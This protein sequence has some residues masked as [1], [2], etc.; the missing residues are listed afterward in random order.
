[1]ACAGGS[2]ESLCLICLLGLLQCCTAS[3]VYVHS[4]GEQFDV[5]ARCAAHDA[6]YFNGGTAAQQNCLENEAVISNWPQNVNMALEHAADAHMCGLHKHVCFSIPE[7]QDKP[8]CNEV[9]TNCKAALRHL[10]AMMFNQSPEMTEPQVCNNFARK[11]VRGI[12]HDFMSN[13]VDGSILSE[14]D[15]SMNFGLCRWAQYINVLSDETSCDPGSIIAMA[16]ELGYEACGVSLWELDVA[17]KPGVTINR[18]YPCG[19]NI[20]GSPMFDSS[21][22]QRKHSFSDVQLA[23]NSTAMEESWY[24]ANGHTHGI[25]DGEVEYSAEAGAAA[26]AIGRVTCPPEGVGEEGLPLT[27][28]TGFFHT[29]RGNLEAPTNPDPLAFPPQRTQGQRFFNEAMHKLGGT[30]CAVG[31]DGYEHPTAG[32]VRIATPQW[33][34]ETE[35]ETDFN[36]EGG[37]C[38]MPTQFLG[39]VRVGGLHRTPRWVSITQ[40]SAKQR[41]PWSEFQSAACRDEIKLYLPWELLSIADV[42]LPTSPALELFRSIAFDGVDSVASA[43]DSCEVGCQIPIMENKLCGGTVG[44]REYDFNKQYCDQGILDPSGHICCDPSC[45]TC[46]QDGQ[47]AAR[48][49]GGSSDGDSGGDGSGDSSV[50]AATPESSSD[51]IFSSAP[52]VAG[53]CVVIYQQGQ[54]EQCEPVPVWDLSDWVHPGGAFVQGSALCGTVRYNWLAKGS[55]STQELDPEAAEML[56]GGGVRVGMYTDSGCASPTEAPTMV[57]SSSGSGSSCCPTKISDEA[58]ECG[59][60]WD[61]GCI[62]PKTGDGGTCTSDAECKHGSCKAGRC[63]NVRGALGGCAACG[64]AGG[65]CVACADGFKPL[66]NECVDECQCSPGCLA[67]S[68]EICSVCSECDPAT[69]YMKSGDW[70]VPSTSAAF[71]ATGLCLPK[72]QAGSACSADY[73]CAQGSCMAGNCCDMSRLEA[74]CVECNSRGLC[75]ACAD[76][77]SLCG[78]SEAQE[79]QCKPT[80]STAMT[81]F[82]C[83][84]GGADS[85]YPSTDGYNYCAMANHCPC[86]RAGCY[87]ECEIER[88]C[89]EGSIASTLTDYEPVF[90]GEDGAGSIS[91]VAPTPANTPALTDPANPSTQVVTWV[92]G[93]YPQEEGSGSCDAVCAAFGDGSECNE[94][95]LSALNNEDAA[96]AAAFAA[97]GNQCNSV[98]RS[99]EPGSN[100][101]SWG[102]PFFHNSNMAGGACSVGSVPSVAPCN[103]RPVDSQHRRLCPC[104][105]TAFVVPTPLPTNSP[106]SLVETS[107]DLPTNAPTNAPTDTPTE[108][109]TV[110]PTNAPTYFPTFDPTPAATMPSKPAFNP[111]DEEYNV[112]MMVVVSES[113]VGKQTLAPTAA[114]TAHP[115]ASGYSVVD[116]QQEVVVVTAALTFPLSTEEASD[117][118]MRSSLEQGFAASLGVKPTKVRVTNINGES[119]VSARRRSRRRMQSWV[120]EKIVSARVLE[121]STQ[122]TFEVDAPSTSAVATLKE[123]VVQAA[124]EGSIVANVQKS[125]SDNG[126]LTPALAEMPRALDAP[127]VAE[128]TRTVAVAVAVRLTGAPVSAPTPA[129]TSED[130][131]T[132][133]LDTNTP[134]KLD[135]TSNAVLS[136]GSSTMMCVIVLTVLSLSPY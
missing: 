11:S 67:N 62:L 36:P 87:M 100:C 133:S 2:T 22:S 61:V 53:C 97:T 56:A 115:T 29:Q 66:G 42:P 33:P 121:S 13:A 92:I 65:N 6:G 84:T 68:C 43:W 72:R 76:G 8:A 113:I 51:D 79:G 63:C 3:V 81:T 77:F 50:D 82:R 78:F 45:G 123:N 27:Y 124:T 86:S 117:P 103:Q 38:S 96:T 95:V 129:P 93:S 131:A 127:T 114:P 10:H 24:A 132:E 32:G 110:D 90:V 25:P 7:Y 20:D 40:N 14:H 109:P 48:G 52:C 105:S 60:S 88:T 59:S 136:G 107:G 128:M 41:K 34:F 12:F 17:V 89:W 80:V 108:S 28:Q 19:M 26:H 99:C 74:G 15:V 39:T 9:V 4:N 106:S 98:S 57:G 37:F 31:T 55:H 58:R 104:S 46:V 125:A 23:T 102:A 69:H 71:E 64:A 16:G 85:D 1:M 118:V 111:S 54:G 44:L 91:S 83:G 35:T 94:A 75:S 101:V 119:V 126:V 70:D 5:N 116:Q 18:P 122:I 130:D 135:Q 120:R 134:T 47:C 30:Q 73:E 49:G 21:T 112:A